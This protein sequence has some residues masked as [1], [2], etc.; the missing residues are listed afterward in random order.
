M[1]YMKIFKVLIYIFTFAFLLYMSLFFRSYYLFM[2]ASFMIFAAL[3][4]IIL[5]F[6]P[7]GS[8]DIEISSDKT[9]YTKGE[10]GEIYITLKNR[11]CFPINNVKLDITVKN[12]FYNEHKTTLVV[13]LPILASKKIT[14]PFEL[15]KSGVVDISAGSIE[16]SDMFG[17]L[18]SVTENNTLYSVI[19]MP[20]KHNI[21]NALLGS[22]ESE[23]IPAVNVYLSN[24]GDVSGYK[25]YKSG[26][27]TNSIN[28]K[29]FAKTEKLYV[30]EFE[31]TSADEA[32]ILMDMNIE[33]LDQAIDI[34]YNIGLKSCNFT[35]LWLPCGS[36]EFESAYISDKASLSNALY[37]IY[38]SVP[39]VIK[40]KALSEYKKL[41]RENKVLYVSNKM[42]LI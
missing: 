13:S 41:Y 5:Y 23:E 42:E 22:V 33:S 10:K 18:K 27:R 4:N 11:K 32:V 39:E 24:S 25:E 31:K 40:D 16:Y 34:V 36:E 12:K 2:G 7:F 14:L 30:R 3:A 8:I 29:L 28:W 6:L 38:N 15:V 20:Q 1:I 37:R 19:T 17:I 35:L 26:D 21:D 9:N